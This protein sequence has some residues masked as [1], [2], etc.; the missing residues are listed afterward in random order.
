MAAVVS[1][2]DKIR[3]QKAVHKE[4]DKAYTEQ[5]MQEDDIDSLSSWFYKTLVGGAGLISIFNMGE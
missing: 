1:G 2:R 4:Q 3:W 5:S